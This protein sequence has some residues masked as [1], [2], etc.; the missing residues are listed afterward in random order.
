NNAA[1]PTYSNTPFNE[2]NNKWLG[3]PTSS[4][5]LGFNWDVKGNQ[6]IVIRG[7]AGIFVG[8]MPFAWSGYAETLSGGYYNNIDFKPS[9]SNTI[10]GSTVIPVAINPS[11]SKDTIDAHAK[12]SANA[13]NTRE[14]DVVDNKFKSPR[15]SRTS[16]AADF[17]FG[18]GYK[19]TG[20]VLYTKTLYDVQ[21]QQI[22]IK[23][24]A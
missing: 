1:H 5:R 17:R 18:N 16:I 9:A 22:N 14:V 2:S 12:P 4:P 19:S 13:S 11:Y 10:G 23:D 6:S 15:I 21:F 3:T 7:G 8:R 20:D 24:Q